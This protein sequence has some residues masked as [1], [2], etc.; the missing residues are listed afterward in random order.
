MSVFKHII[1][2]VSIDKTMEMMQDV[3]PWL[4]NTCNL[5]IGFDE[6]TFTENG[7]YKSVPTYQFMTYDLSNK[8]KIKYG[9]NIYVIMQ[10]IKDANGTVTNLYIRWKAAKNK[11]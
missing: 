5:A 10:T 2:Q 1:T 6:T 9:S 8:L 11:K 3:A 7:V 4:V